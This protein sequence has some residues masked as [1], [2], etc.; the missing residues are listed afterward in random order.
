MRWQHACNMT[1]LIRDAKRRCVGTDS[2]HKKKHPMDGKSTKV[3]SHKTEKGR[4]GTPL[5]GRA[6]SQASVGREG[7]PNT[8][9]WTL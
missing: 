8:W 7:T 2:F 1:D 9:V 4:M 3:V 6:R 5:R